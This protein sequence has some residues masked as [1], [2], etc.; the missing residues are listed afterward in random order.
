MAAAAAG[1]PA[2]IMPSVCLFAQPLALRSA[3]IGARSISAL[4]REHAASVDLFQKA[5]A[6]VPNPKFAIGSEA[7]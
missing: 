6:S 3:T 4:L 5:N 2:F 7:V 1:M